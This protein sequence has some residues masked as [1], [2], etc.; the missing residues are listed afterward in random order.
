V[1]RRNEAS[2]MKN[3]SGI[4][5]RPRFQ[6]LE[7]TGKKLPPETNVERGWSAKGRPATKRIKEAVVVKL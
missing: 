1:K 6:T 2:E 3:Q 7:K 4:I 5:P